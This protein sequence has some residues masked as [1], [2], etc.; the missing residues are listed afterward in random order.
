MVY[1]YIVEINI[2]YLIC[3]K[4]GKWVMFVLKFVLLGVMFYGLV[5]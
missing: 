1:Y 4:N 3:G 2:V 5:K